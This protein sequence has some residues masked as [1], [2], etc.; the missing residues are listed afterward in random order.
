[1]YVRIRHTTPISL[2][3]RFVSQG[4]HDQ[5]I[6]V[7]Y[8][9]LG[10]A[11]GALLLLIAACAAQAWVY[12]DRIYAWYSVYAGVMTLAVAAYTGVAGHLLW[13]RQRLLGRCVAGRAGPAGRGC[14]A[15]VR[16]PA[17]RYA[18]ALSLADRAVYFSGLG[19]RGAG[20]H[21]SCS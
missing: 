16:A 2:P 10:M 7:E 6:Q 11:F 3:V 15:A 18:G 1:M 14:R 13:S 5:R 20:C 8:M 19:G 4:G 9:G 12:R 21:F 17:G